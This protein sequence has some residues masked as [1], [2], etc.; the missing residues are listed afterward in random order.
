MSTHLTDQLWQNLSELSQPEAISTI[1]EVIYREK[2]TMA[3]IFYSYMMQ[4]AEAAGFLSAATVESHLKPGL[5]RW[6]VALLCKTSDEDMEAALAMQRHVGEV[7]ARAEIPVGLVARGMRILKYEINM[8]LVATNLNRN[9]L[10]IAVLRVNHLIDIAFEVMSTAYINSQEHGIRTEEAFRTYSAGHNLAMERE[11]QQGAILEWENRLFRTM[12]NDLSL[13]NF[14]PMNISPLGLWLRHKAPLIFGAIP[15]LQLIEESIRRVDLSL[16]PQITNDAI[17]DS[18]S[19]IVRNIVKNICGEAEQIKYLLNA[20][21]E[22]LSAMEVGRDA[23]TQ[24]LNRRFL[25]TILKREVELSRRKE[26]T[27]SVLMIDID[28]FKNV[29]DEYGHEAGDHALQ[30]V[31]SLIMNKARAGDF[32]FR[33]GGEE[34][35]MILTE[36]NAVQA[37]SVAEKIRKRVETADILLSNDRAIK[38]TLSIGVAMSDGNPDYQRLIERADTALYSAKNNGRNICVLAEH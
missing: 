22:R 38:I 25:P 35:L 29:N 34:F 20:M 18:R 14:L 5:E 37:M 32:A 10:V 11:K 2:K 12:A 4:N 17:Q 26:E 1:S 13:D 16:L 31:A 36:V 27:F 24:L 8:H 6:M 15:E 9:D 28:F 21:F 19:E 7:H 23:L 33:Y 3:E 30:Q